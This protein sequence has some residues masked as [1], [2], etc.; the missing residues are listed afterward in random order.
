MKMSEDNKQFLIGAGV[1]VGVY[2][3]IKTYRYRK[4]KKANQRKVENLRK[5]IKE[6]DRFITDLKFQRIINEEYN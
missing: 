1:T 2:A 5:T 4:I 3:V 6:M